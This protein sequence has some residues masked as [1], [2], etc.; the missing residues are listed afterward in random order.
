[1]YSPI[2]YLFTKYSVT[3]MKLYMLLASAART[4]YA[5]FVSVVGLASGAGV[6]RQDGQGKSEAACQGIRRGEA[7]VE[8]GDE[9]EGRAQ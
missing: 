6:D 4:L 1:M 5:V 2:C 7:A 3:I 9:G 8:S